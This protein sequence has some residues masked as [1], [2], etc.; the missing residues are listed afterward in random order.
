MGA[1]IPA[2]AFVPPTASAMGSDP[3]LYKPYNKVTS[4]AAPSAP[5][6]GGSDFDMGAMMRAFI[7]AMGQN[8]A[9]APQRLQL[10]RDAIFGRHLGTGGGAVTPGDPTGSGAFGPE[11]LFHGGFASQLSQDQLLKSQGASAVNQWR[12][13]NLFPGQAFRGPT[14][15]A[16]QGNVLSTGVG[17][18]SSRGMTNMDTAGGGATVY[19]PRMDRDGGTG[20]LSRYDTALAGAPRTAAPGRRAPRMFQ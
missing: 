13:P 15:N 20:I 10:N 9:M 4:P 8:A 3:S 5:G 19:D 1:T 18:T 12:Q 6:A 2:S 11:G 7:S 16:A 14:P 17:P